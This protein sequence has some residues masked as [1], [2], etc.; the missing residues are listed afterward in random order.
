M[1]AAGAMGITTCGTRQS[2]SVPDPRSSSTSAGIGGGAGAPLARRANWDTACLL[3]SLLL[4][5]HCCEVCRLLLLPAASAAAVAAGPAAPAGEGCRRRAEASRQGR[6]GRAAA[7]RGIA[8]CS[9]GHC[10]ATA[11][12]GMLGGERAR[13]GAAG[14]HF[15]SQ[16]TPATCPRQSPSRARRRTCGAG[17]GPQ[18]VSLKARGVWGAAGPARGQTRP[19]RQAPTAGS[20]EDIHGPPE[21]VCLREVAVDDQGSPPLRAGAGEWRFSCLT[22]SHGGTLL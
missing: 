7:S 20:L 16:K 19:G 13:G 8:C 1:G 5:L 17:G 6:L 2:S 10:A 15:G 12:R 22:N 11:A 9:G 14:A 21:A 18:A 3:L 4:A